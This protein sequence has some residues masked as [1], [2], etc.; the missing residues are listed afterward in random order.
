MDNPEQPSRSSGGNYG[1]RRRDVSVPRGAAGASRA[2]AA[3]RTQ[4]SARQASRQSAQTS[5]PAEAR[6]NAQPIID[7]VPVEASRRSEQSS[8]GAHAASAGFHAART[9]DAAHGEMA[10]SSVRAS[11]NGEHLVRVRKK[12]KDRRVLKAV[13]IVLAVIVALL[14]VAGAAVA[15]YIN[16]LNSAISYEDPEQ[17]QQLQ[18]VLDTPV[19]NEPY[20]VLVLG[21]DAREGDTASRSDVIMLARIAPSSSSSV[22]T[23]VS[24]PR[25]TKVEL[26]GYGTSKINAAYAYGGAAGAVE[27]VENFSGVDISHVV[28]I[29]FQELETLIDSLGGVWVNV[30]VT[31]ELAS[32]T[33]EKG[34]QLLT[35]EQALQFVRERYSYVRGDFQRSDNQRLVAEA[36]IR[37]VLDVPALELPGTIQ[38]LATCVT[39]DLSVTDVVGLVQEIQQSRVITFYSCMAPSTTATIDGVSYTI[40]L[41]DE[42]EEMMRLV[43]EGDDPATASSNTTSANADQSADR[44]DEGDEGADASTLM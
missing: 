26:P 20:Y 10:E 17:K 11:A 7:V 4:A 41:E 33:L 27:A 12:K 5:R 18:T 6:Q 16:S 39:T 28:E 22:I 23:L 21:S 37:K 38:Q 24:I 31:T 19:K 15:L 40:S 32:G 42:W 36:I 8:H 34:N 30:P 43:D 35:G 29:H 1:R 25:D 13:L 9:A 44:S 14:L 3:D 2:N